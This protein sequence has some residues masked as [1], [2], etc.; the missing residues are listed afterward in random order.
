MSNKIKPKMTQVQHN[1]I[2]IQPEKQGRPRPTTTTV[3]ISKEEKLQ[4]LE[5]KPEKNMLE[6]EELKTRLLEMEKLKAQ[7]LEME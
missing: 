6:M 3:Q 2:H 7:L 4:E 1:A 5:T